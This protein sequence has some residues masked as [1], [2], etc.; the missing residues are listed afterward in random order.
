MFLTTW[1]KG[2][3]NGPNAIFPMLGLRSEMDRLFDS[4]LRE[5]FGSLTTRMG[6]VAAWT[7][8][9]D[10]SETEK[11]YTVRAE[12]PGIDPKQIEVS[13]SDNVL[14]IAGEKKEK[15]EK[16]EKN[17]HFSESYYGSFRRTVPLPAAVDS[18]KVTAEYADG[19]LTVKVLKVEEAR[20]KKVEIKT[21]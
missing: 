3:G 1:K 7:P 4:F 13:I 15:T 6:D 11:E 20:P 10:L 2:N 14:T 12:V 21:T 19:V 9:V 5:P 8:A 18:D 16:K 17:Y